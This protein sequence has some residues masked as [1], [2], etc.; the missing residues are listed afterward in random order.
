M[1][2]AEEGANGGL[3]PWVLPTA[4]E[5]EHRGLAFRSHPGSKCREERAEVRLRRLFQTGAKK[6]GLIEENAG[7]EQLREE[8]SEDRVPGKA[9]EQEKDL[10]PP[11]LAGMRTELVE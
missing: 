7:G 2:N 6:V 5:A 4:Q 1:R 9:G 8:R 11:L 3:D 10:L